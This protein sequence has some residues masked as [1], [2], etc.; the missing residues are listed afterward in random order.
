MPSLVHWSWK[1]HGWEMKKVG[2]GC[3]LSVLTDGKVYNGVGHLPWREPNVRWETHRKWEELCAI[4]KCGT[5]TKRLNL[6]ITC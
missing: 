5:V 6:S 2:E 4:D 3:I 1:A